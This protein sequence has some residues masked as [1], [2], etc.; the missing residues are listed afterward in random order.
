M[1]AIGA[2][3]GLKYSQYKFTPNTFGRLTFRI[4]VLLIDD[5]DWKPYFD[6]GNVHI[7]K[8]S[9]TIA[10]LNNCARIEIVSHSYGLVGP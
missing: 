8:Q 1:G 2:L 6:R 7:V 4:D 10:P 9:P 3:P 5:S